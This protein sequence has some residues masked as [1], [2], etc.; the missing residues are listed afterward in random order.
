MSVNN[1]QNRGKDI[2]CYKSEIFFCSFSLCYLTCTRVLQISLKKKK[3]TSFP[4]ENFLLRKNL[5]HKKKRKIVYN[6]DF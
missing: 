4:V 2:T 6:Y 5:I 3:N 1:Y